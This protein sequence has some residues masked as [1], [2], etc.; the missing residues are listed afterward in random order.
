M[1]LW[2]KRETDGH[3]SELSE[4]PSVAEYRNWVNSL[5]ICDTRMLMA[6]V[7]ERRNGEYSIV[8]ILRDLDQTD[9]DDDGA[10]TRAFFETAGRIQPIVVAP[11]K[12]N[13]DVRPIKG[14][15]DALAD[16]LLIVRLYKEDGFHLGVTSMQPDPPQRTADALFALQRQE[17][18]QKRVSAAA[19]RQKAV[20]QKKKK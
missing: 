9:Y 16:D 4:S 20:Q 7:S 19:Q 17:E 12:L 15:G 1:A 2:R 11:L 5:S 14:V 10:L 3:M 18:A 8:A 13:T 6:D